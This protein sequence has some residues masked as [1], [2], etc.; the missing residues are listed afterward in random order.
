MNPGILFVFF[1]RIVF[2]SNIYSVLNML[3]WGA[4]YFRF[5]TMFVELNLCFFSYQKGL[6]VKMHKRL[7]FNAVDV[8]FRVKYILAH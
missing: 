4:N 6:E 1:K 3:V 7:Y 2:I 8:G 5:L